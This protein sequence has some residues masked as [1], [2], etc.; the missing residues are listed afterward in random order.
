MDH[1][2]N[3]YLEAKKR[4]KEIREFYTHLITFIVVC[5]AL[6]LIN[7]LTNYWAYPWF[8]W[9]V[10]GWGIGLAFDAAKTFRLNPFYNK[11]W[12][13]RKIKEYMEKENRQRWE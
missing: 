7:Y 5:S 13:E 4:V 6:A 10:F 3:S 11:D 2:N 8:L 12:E 9:A 1:Q